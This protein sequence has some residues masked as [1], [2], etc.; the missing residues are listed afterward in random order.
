MNYILSTKC[1]YCPLLV[2]FSILLCV[3]FHQIFILHAQYFVDLYRIAKLRTG[4][5][6]TLIRNITSTRNDSKISRYG[7]WVANSGLGGH[8]AR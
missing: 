5:S 2:R 4:F 1:M 3:L 8:F 7:S 6:I